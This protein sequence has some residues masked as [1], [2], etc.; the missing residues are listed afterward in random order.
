[1]AAIAD[2]ETVRRKAIEVVSRPEFDLSTSNENAPVNW[3]LRILLWLLKP[4]GWFL[5]SLGGLSLPLK[6]LI[7]TALVL[8]LA[9]LLAHIVYSFMRAF[10]G[11][12]RRDYVPAADP[13]L[14]P[15]VLEATARKRASEGDF[16][17]AIRALF[18]AALVRIE[19]TESKPLRKG[20]TNR[21]ILKRYRS[22]RL[23]EPLGKFIELIDSRWYGYVP[24]ERLD[25]VICESEYEQ[26]RNVLEGRSHAVRP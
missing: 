7:V 24:C 4:I 1:M 19:Q 21:E 9:A 13:P 26:I 2:P 11:P 14:R 5:E 17:G 6:I 15:E 25:F 22:S 16:I 23:F 3:G 10:R 12:A 8:L 20:I 18:K